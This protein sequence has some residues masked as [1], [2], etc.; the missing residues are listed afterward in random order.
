MQHAHGAK[1]EEEHRGQ[2]ED[3]ADIES[4]PHGQPLSFDYAKRRFA[5]VG[6]AWPSELLANH[7]P[8]VGSSASDD[9]SLLI[10]DE[11]PSTLR[12]M[13]FE[14]ESTAVVAE[15]RTIRGSVLEQF[16]QGMRFLD[17][18]NTNGHWP[19][20]AMRESLVN[21]MEH[22]DYSYSGPTVIKVFTTRIEII[23]L[24]G[25]VG[26]LEVNDLLNGV[27][28]PRDELLANCFEILG[29]CENSGTGVQ[30]IMDSYSTSAISPQLRVAPSS[31]AMIL[32]LP[33]KADAHWSGRPSWDQETTSQHGHGDD[34]G[35]SPSQS[36]KRY[37]FPVTHPY[38]THDSSAALAGMRVIG[39]RPLQI[40]VLGRQEFVWRII[41][42][43][44][45]GHGS[46]SDAAIF[47]QVPMP[48]AQPLITLEEVTLHCLANAGVPLSRAQIQQSLG[49]NKNQTAHLLHTLS[50]QGRIRM[51]GQSRATRYSLP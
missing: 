39:A 46:G 41:G 23:S 3:A 13:A 25:L 42:D 32:P 40:A 50:E 5:K 1:R 26:D 11:C 49:L 36:A 6:V 12:C 7:H 37:P 19:P 4:G 20:P 33:V 29:L 48:Q 24:G 18:H 16:D 21:A 27:C 31:L 17:A 35:L 14:G 44:T 43:P 28:Q 38:T 45:S 51:Q 47:Q 22:R 9:T 30:R 8:P 15:H 10:S 34:G 2:A